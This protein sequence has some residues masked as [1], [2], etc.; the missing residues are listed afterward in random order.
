MTDLINPSVGQLIIVFL[1][2]LCAVFVISIGLLSVLLRDSNEKLGM[3]IERES[4]LKAEIEALKDSNERLST[5]LLGSDE[6]L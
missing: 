3:A 6:E 5:E 2:G 1:I 4:Y